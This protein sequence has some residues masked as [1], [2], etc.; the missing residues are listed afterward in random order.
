[1][2]HLITQASLL[3]TVVK[4]AAAGQLKHLKCIVYLDDLTQEQVAS[5]EKSLG[6]EL[7]S[8]DDLLERG[9]K[10]VASA[11]SSRT[12]RRQV[13]PEDLCVIMFTSGST[14]NPK[15]VMMSHR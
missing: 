6:M 1:M 8:Y 15:G 4:A 10:L 14:G 13:Q 3:D 5:Y 9:K 11:G 2:T 12:P 7:V